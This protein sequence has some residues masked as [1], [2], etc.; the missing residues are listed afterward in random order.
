MKLFKKVREIC[1]IGVGRYGAAIADQLLKDRENNIR[2]VLVD[3][4]EKHLTPYKDEVEMIYVADCAEQKTL[5]ALNMKDFDVVI[6][7]ASNNI[8]IVAAL[9]E[10]GVKSIIARAT[11]PRHAQVLRQIGVTLIVS[12]EEEAGKR[13]ALLVANPNLALYSKNMVEL[14]DGFVSA[15]IHIQNADVFN[16]KISELGF[17]N[18]YHVSVTMI[19][20][21]NMTYLPEGDFEILEN[22]LLTFI[23]KTEDIVDVL[24]FCAH[25]KNNGNNKKEKR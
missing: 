20:R 23:G 5:E 6:V 8:E 18:K 24:A 19:N 14:Q 3:G 16:K 15:S 10:M 1:I 7:S 22:D 13:T 2:V 9:A 4:D 21:N 25:T 11:S 12:P 17:R